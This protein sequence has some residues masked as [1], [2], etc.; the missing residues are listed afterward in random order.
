MPSFFP[1][2]YILRIFCGVFLPKYLTI[3]V[4]FI[5]SI[6]AASS[7]TDGMLIF[8]RCQPDG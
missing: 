3:I 8:A 4:R 5:L 2:I 1:A 6:D 7:V